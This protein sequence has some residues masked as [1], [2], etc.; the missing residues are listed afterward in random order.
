MNKKALIH[1]VYILLI[2][3]LAGI[4]FN[5]SNPNRIQFV[6]NEKRVDFSASDSLLNALRIQDSLQ[7]AADSLLKLSGSREDSL[8]LALEKHKQDSILAANKTDSLKRIQDSV[9][10]ANQKKEDSI[11]NAQNQVTEIV[12]PVDIKIDFAKALFDKKYRF[13]DA[14]DAAD[15]NAGHIQGAMNIPFHEIEKYKDRL[16]DLP[17][18]QVYVTYCSAA[19]DVSIDMA[20]YMAK[21][22][23]KKVYIFHGGWDEWKAAGYP[24]N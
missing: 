22:G 8:R 15:F 3:L 23:F 24:A 17:K 5:I 18:D 12:K 6:A 7:K 16:N 14:R 10:A 21:M 9:N 19:C 13:L 11:K 2:T 20:Y 4:F 1:I